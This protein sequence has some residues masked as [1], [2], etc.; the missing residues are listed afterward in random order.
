[1]LANFVN[2][3]DVRMLQSRHRFGFDLEADHLDGPGLIAIQN[4][5]QGHVSVRPDL[6]GLIDDPHPT[7]TEFVL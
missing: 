3:H 6:A 2:R 4:H 7:S 1:M 5:L